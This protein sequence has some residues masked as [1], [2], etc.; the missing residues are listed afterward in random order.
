ME[1][2]EK[3][4]ENHYIYMQQPHVEELEVLSCVVFYE[5]FFN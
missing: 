4:K 3:E 1:E 2:R 5:I